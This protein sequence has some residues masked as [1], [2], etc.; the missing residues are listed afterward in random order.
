MS[1]EAHGG[2]SRG[3]FCADYI[4]DEKLVCLD[5]G[6]PHADM[7]DFESGLSILEVESPCFHRRFHR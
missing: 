4:A 2:S 5:I 7:A 1:Y 6:Y 3:K